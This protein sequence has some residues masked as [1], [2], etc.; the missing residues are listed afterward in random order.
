[1]RSFDPEDKEEWIGRRERFAIVVGT[2]ALMLLMGALNYIRD[3]AS[4]K[5]DSL[6]ALLTDFIYKQGTSFGVLARGYIYKSNLP[7]RDFRNYTFGPIIDYFYRGNIGIHLFGA[8]PFSTT[9][10]SLEMALNSNSYAHSLSYLAI[11]EAYL[12]GHGIGG[13]YI[14]DIFT[15]YGYVG[16]II[17]NI[18]LGF[19]LVAMMQAAYQKK[20]L[21]MIITLVVLGEIFFTSRSSFSSSFFYLFTMQFWVIIILIFFATKLLMK[22]IQYKTKGEI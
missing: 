7:I 9:T 6:F 18:I 10:N 8:K 15:D 22:K 14:M 12:N 5:F 16:I 4:V 1:M 19:I 17:F 2:P 3:G 20:V 13:S 11:D 21:P